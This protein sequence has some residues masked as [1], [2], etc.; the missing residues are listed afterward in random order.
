MYKR[1]LRIV[2]LGEPRAAS[3]AAACAARLGEGR[4]EGRAR[5]PSGQV[6]AAS[7]GQA[8]TA[9]LA[10]EDLAWADLCVSLDPAVTLPTA[11]SGLAVRYWT[12]APA[13]TDDAAYAA[14]LGTHVAGILGGL[15]LL[16]RLD[17]SP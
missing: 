12:G 16:D 5:V 9:E 17:E 8:D 10:A 4:I 2:F 11:R 7:A 14:F 3:A 13:M 6:V 15:R 1:A